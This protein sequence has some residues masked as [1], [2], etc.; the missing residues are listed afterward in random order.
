MRSPRKDARYR[1]AKAAGYRAR[2]AYKLIELDDRHRLLGRGRRVVD[3]G[4]WP[5]SWLQVAAERVGPEGRVVGID[6][7]AID[8]LPNANVVV[9][10]GDVGDRGVLSAARD[11]LGGPA[12]VLLSDAAPKLTG[13]RATDDAR[14][15]A[16]A[17][18]VLGAT[19][20]LLAPKGA[21]L[22]KLFV[23]PAGD[24]ARAEI[25]RRFERVRAMRP[26]STRRGSS[27]L[28][29]VAEGLRPDFCG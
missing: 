29:V 4:A 20:I 26:E 17:G 5:G 1:L 11:A 2:S 27:E 19:S 16:L 23:G 15:E 21:L 10:T 14:F 22:M 18:D 7:E 24:A 9:L 12:D 6:L 28:Y 25:R 3:V 8:P 13:I